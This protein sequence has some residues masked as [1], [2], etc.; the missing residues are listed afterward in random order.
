MS[1]PGLVPVLPDSAPFTPEQRAYLNGFFAGLFSRASAGGTAATPAPTGRPLQPLTVLFGS[2]TGTAERLAKRIA[3]DAGQ[4]GFAATIHDLSA[5]PVSRLASEQSVLVVTSTYGDGEPPDNA[6]TFWEFLSGPSA[7]ALA[8]M[9]FSV[10]ALGD[11]NYP[12]FCAFGRSVDEQLAKLGA[13][14]AHPRVDCD[15]EFEAPFTAWLGAALGGLTGGETPTAAV[16]SG[17]VPT[18]AKSGPTPRP[19]P[20]RKNPCPAPLITNRRLNA[21]GSA[22]DTRHFEFS[23]E[24]TGLVYTAGDALGVYPA[25][26]PDLAA[27]IVRALGCSGDELVPGPEAGAPELPLREALI[28]QYDITRIQPSLIKAL[29]AM[30][31]AEPLEKLSAPDVNGELTE[32]VRGR[33]V[34]DLLLTYPQARF[35]P[36]AFVGLLKKLQ[37]RLYSISSSPAAHAGQVH[38]CVGVVRYESLGRQRKGVCSTF[39]AERVS[40]SQP[41]RVFHHSNSNFRLPAA[42]ETPMIMV[43][44]GTGIAPFRGFLHERRAIGATGRHWLFFGDQRGATDFLFRD[45]LETFRKDGHLARLDTAFSRDQAGKVYVQ[46]RMLEQAAELFAWL[47]AGA[48]FYVCGDASRMAKDVDAALHQVVRTAGGRTESQAADYV[49]ALKVAKRYQRDVY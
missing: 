36:A 37:P 14:C 9:K 12:R 8:G 6:R 35:G 22:K 3:R 44:P 39:L 40:N 17:A 18:P 1:P 46:D 26:C 21:E 10:C 29:A 34:I 2:Q 30:T 15:V 32:F 16:D 38:L 24:G 48:Q 28:S 19:G 11:S 49:K 23:V 4:R 20:D 5:Y 25:N 43:G 47:E 31:K 33:E 45:E 7:P 42:P 27:E 13:R 41:V